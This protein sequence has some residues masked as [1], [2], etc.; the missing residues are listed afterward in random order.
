[1]PLDVGVGILLSIGVAEWFGVPLSPWLVLFGITAALLP[2]SD[3]VTA[4]FGRW[5]HRMVTHFPLV[6][7]PFAIALFLLL[8]PAYGALF[9]LGIVAHFLHDTIGIGYGVAWLWPFSPRKYL[10]PDRYRRQT[11]GWFVSWMPEEEA[12]IQAAPRR[13][14][15]AHWLTDYYFRPNLGA[16]IEYGVLAASLA[17]LVAY[18]R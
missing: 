16:Y 7:V 18:I 12:R 13:P 9:L 1:M 5:Q 10:F 8:G 6:Y 4:A 15:A 11:L 14:N 17:M 3:I 2:D